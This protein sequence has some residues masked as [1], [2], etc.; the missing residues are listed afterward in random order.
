MSRDYSA[1]AKWWWREI[2]DREKPEARALAARLRRAV[3]DID[4]AAEMKVHE[5]ANAHG[6]GKQALPLARV[7]A[8]IRA[9]A[10]GVLAKRLGPGLKDPVL[11]QYRFNRL[12]RSEDSTLIIALR[13]VLPMVDRACN[14]AVLTRD[15]LNWDE[16]TRIR[17][18][19]DYYN[20]AVPDV[21]KPRVENEEV[22]Q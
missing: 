1:V 6:L 21:V 15:F 17:W 19:F 22:I 2:G 7:L 10:G 13:R 8:E 5:L 11:S 3:S 9:D 20:S 14:V 4:I 16:Q 12:I 18:T